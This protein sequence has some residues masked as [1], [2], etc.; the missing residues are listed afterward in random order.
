MTVTPNSLLPLSSPNRPLKQVCGANWSASN[1]SSHGSIAVFHV[2]SVE[3]RIF[4]LRVKRPTSPLVSTFSAHPGKVCSIETCMNSSGLSSSI[5]VLSELMDFMKRTSFSRRLLL[6]EAITISSPTFQ[7]GT[8]KI[9]VIDVSPGCTVEASL[10]HV[11]K[12]CLPCNPRYPVR[13]AIDFAPYTGSSVDR[14]CPWMVIRASCW[15]GS[16]SVPRF[17]RFDFILLFI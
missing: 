14:T 9:R 6:V 4:T 16:S 17:I 3:P 12:M 15:N 8:A 5:T 7:P 2:A 11:C 1:S 13:R 10:V